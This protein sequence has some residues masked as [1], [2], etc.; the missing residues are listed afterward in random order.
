MNDYI[1]KAIDWAV[2]HKILV[3]GIA[4]VVLLAIIAAYNF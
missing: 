2:E 1:T 3:G 4:A